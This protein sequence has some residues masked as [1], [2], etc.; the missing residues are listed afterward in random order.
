VDLAQRLDALEQIEEIK[1]LKHGYWRACDAKDPVRFRSSFIRSGA[2]IDY[3]RLGSFDDAGPMADIF[4]KIALRKVDGRYA[5]LDMHHGL[6]PDIA[7][8]SET[9]A[10][11]RWTLQFR[12]VD[13][14]G[15]TEKLM[16]GEYDDKYVIEDGVWKM[17]Q[18]HFTETWSITTPL[19][20]DAD[21]TEGSLG[22]P[23]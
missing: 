10:V 6:H 7:L 12:Q 19:S 14:V 16:T 11:G 15:R 1:K 8:T 23:R 18:C 13:T 21:I 20:P 17:S 4:E 22:G 9:S 2:S 3:G 5:V